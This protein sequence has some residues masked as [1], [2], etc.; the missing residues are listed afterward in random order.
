[1]VN[2]G[3]SGLGNVEGGRGKGERYSSWSGP[4]EDIS[5]RTVGEAEV[6]RR[7]R[8]EGDDQVMQDADADWWLEMDAV[9]CMLVVVVCR[10]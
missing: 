7:L 10:P 3:E 4:G 9:V 5:A 6:G 2:W 1:M 8:K